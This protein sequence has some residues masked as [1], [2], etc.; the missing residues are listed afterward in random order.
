MNQRNVCLQWM[1]AKGVV[2]QI[3]TNIASE[4]GS[5]NTCCCRDEI[6]QSKRQID[7]NDGDDDGGDGDGDGD[8]DND[9]VGGAKTI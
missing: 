3:C 4:A 9:D 7:N 2:L 5:K 1:K 8:D 6:A